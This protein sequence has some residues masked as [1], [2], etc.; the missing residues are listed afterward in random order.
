MKGEA[1]AE[2]GQYSRYPVIKC[3]AVSVLLS[4]SSRIALLVLYFHG[5]V[6]TLLV[7]TSFFYSRKGDS[8]LV[9]FVVRLL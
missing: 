2:C 6:K 8:V 1:E 3:A 7:Q 5:T 9:A 4:D